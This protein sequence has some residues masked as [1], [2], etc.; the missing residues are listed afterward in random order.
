MRPLPRSTRTVVV[1]AMLLAALLVA[2]CSDGRRP[3][4]PVRGKVLFEERPTPDALV[5][6]HPL[7]DPDPN[8][9]RPIARVGADGSFSPTTYT[10]NDG[11][12]AGRY[13]VTVTWVEER[14]NQNAP[15]EDQRPARNRLPDRYGRAET[16]K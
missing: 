3:V 1:S 10:T 13:A 8:A 2:G 14:D 11:A 7:D 9:P 15:K 5:I 12:P 16:S 6:F 4:F